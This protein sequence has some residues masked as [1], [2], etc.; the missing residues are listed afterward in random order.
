M[1]SPAST[2]IERTILL[3]LIFLIFAHIVYGQ[4]LA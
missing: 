3:N 1:L 4:I 2:P